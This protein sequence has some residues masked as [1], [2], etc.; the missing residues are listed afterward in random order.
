MQEV[1]SSDHDLL[2]RIWTIL[3]GTNGSGLITRFG[4]MELDVATIK[5]TLPNLWTREQH[6]ESIKEYQEDRK[7]KKERRKLTRRDWFLI[8]GTILGSLASIGLFVV[9]FFTLRGR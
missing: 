2:V 1:P 7:D 4:C 3:E 9:A 5:A 6:N 8:F